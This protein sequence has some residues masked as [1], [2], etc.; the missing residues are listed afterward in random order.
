MSVIKI[1]TQFLCAIFLASSLIGMENEILF[2]I[3]NR[4]SIEQKDGW[5][6]GYFTAFHVCTYHKWL[7]QNGNF[8]GI[9]LNVAD[10]QT[11]FNTVKNNPQIDRVR[12]DSLS[13]KE[14]YRQKKWLNGNDIMAIIQVMLNTHQSIRLPDNITYINKKELEQIPL[15]SQTYASIAEYKKNK[16]PQFVVL[17]LS[18]YHWFLAIVNEHGLDI[19]D[20]LYKHTDSEPLLEKLHYLYNDTFPTFP[21]VKKIKKYLS[22]DEIRQQKTFN[23]KEQL[24][25]Q[26]A[27]NNQITIT[28]HHL[29]A[30][31]TQ[32]ANNSV[33]HETV[34][35]EDPEDKPA[36]RVLEIFD[37][38]KEP[39]ENQPAQNSGFFDYLRKAIFNSAT[40][41]S[42][43]WNKK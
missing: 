29:E 36:N 12:N 19:I 6:C 24:A 41:M 43:Y 7:T 14:K 30:L 39:I 23:V 27:I 40:K 38:E 8:N 25:Q 13:L 34:V 21:Q 35:L 42:N 15:E 5:Q 11:W 3:E 28:D 26:F 33:I 2:S 20:S 22:S 37:N 18:N 9:K 10:Y 31:V 16:S 4:A 1:A 32:Y 17:N